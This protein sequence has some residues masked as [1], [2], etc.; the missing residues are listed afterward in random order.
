MN[1]VQTTARRAFAP[2]G[3]LALLAFG[4]TTLAVISAIHLAGATPERQAARQRLRRRNRR[5]PSRLVLVSAIATNLRHSPRGWLAA[6]TAVG[7]A[8]VGFL[9]GLSFTLRG[10]SN[11]DIAYHANML[12]ILIATLA[13]LLRPS[14][15]E[16]QRA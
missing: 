12:P 7:F 13:L 14:R 16:S 1:H 5:K 11:A 15:L 9:L 4:A 3:I 8:I 6:V 2:R 10:G